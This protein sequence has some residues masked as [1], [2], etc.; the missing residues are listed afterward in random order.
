[1]SGSLITAAWDY[2]FNLAFCRKI[3]VVTKTILHV[4]SERERDCVHRFK[5]A[6]MASLHV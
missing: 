3:F 4:I 1:M 6:T 2:L 5:D